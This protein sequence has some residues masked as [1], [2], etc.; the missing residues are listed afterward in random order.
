[1]KTWSF[2]SPNPTSW[3]KNRKK[4]TIR[5]YRLSRKLREQVR[6]IFIWQHLNWKLA[7]RLKTK[8]KRGRNIKRKIL[9]VRKKNTLLLNTLIAGE[10]KGRIPKKVQGKA[11]PI[12]EEVSLEGGAIPNQDKL[13]CLIPR[14]IVRLKDSP[15]N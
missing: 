4:N 10:I 5:R 11:N 15:K 8:S 13:E 2:I 6:G 3:M 7:V 9:I 12:E 1:M 14:K